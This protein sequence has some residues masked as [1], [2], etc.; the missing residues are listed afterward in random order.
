[1]NLR[2]T[3]LGGLLLALPAACA[4]SRSSERSPVSDEIVAPSSMIR[5]DPPPGR[6]I[7]IG[8][9]VP[10]HQSGA[11]YARVVLC[12]NRHGAVLSAAT[13]L[14]SAES[15]DELALER[16]VK[17]WKYR[18]QTASLCTYQDFGRVP[19][20]IP[21]PGRFT[22]ASLRINPQDDPYRVR[23]PA[24][25]SDAAVKFR[26]VL[27]LDRTGDVSEVTVVDPVPAS[28]Q[29]EAIKTLR[30]WKF[31]PFTVNGV[32]IRKRILYTIEIRY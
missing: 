1:M 32:G 23:V 19:A 15:I 12:P 17:T 7:E 26:V 8:D 10:E 30:R 25:I 24:E 14:R 2:K 22:W 27:S 6:Q 28:L 16:T 18:P 31:D 29:R 21:P 13:V 4:A 5:I 3:T 20:V 9:L 11:S